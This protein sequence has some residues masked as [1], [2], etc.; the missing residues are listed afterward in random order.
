MARPFVVCEFQFTE[1]DFLSHPVS[2]CVWGLRVDIDFVPLNKEKYIFQ[3]LNLRFP[4][5]I[6]QNSTENMGLSIRKSWGTHVLLHGLV[7]KLW[8]GY[9][10]S[11]FLF[12]CLSFFLTEKKSLLGDEIVL[13]PG[14][15]CF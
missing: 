13:N 15:F 11:E 12:L 6:T 4:K 1:G 2:P 8:L 5:Q 10:I 3:Y 9:K 14:E 7:E